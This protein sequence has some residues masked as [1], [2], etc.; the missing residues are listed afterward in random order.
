MQHGGYGVEKEN[1]KVEATTHW[2]LLLRIQIMCMWMKRKMDERL[3]KV[4][5]GV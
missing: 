2:L 4:G 1:I 3:I 5:G